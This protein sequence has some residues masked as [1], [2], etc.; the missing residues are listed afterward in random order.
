MDCDELNKL[1]LE[2]LHFGESL[3][4]EISQFSNLDGISKLQRKI[5]QELK[6]LKKVNGNLCTNTL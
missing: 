5:N 4:E 1:L 6:F 2:K 3:I